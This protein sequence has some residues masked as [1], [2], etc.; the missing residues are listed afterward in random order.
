MKIKLDEKH[1]KW[2]LT[3]FLVILCSI[4]VFFAIYRFDVVSN[5]FHICGKILAPFIYGL[6]MAY[7]LCPMYNF[8]VRNTYALFGRGGKK[9]SK[10]LVI[11]KIM[12]TVVSMVFLLVVIAGVLWMIIPGVIDS[13]TKIVD[14]LPTGMENVQVWLDQRFENIPTAQNMV[15]GW[16]ENITSNTINFVTETLLPEYDNIALS[17]SE[18]VISM[19]GMLM[20]L[21]IGMVICVYF[22][23]SKDVFA[24]QV[25]KIVIGHFKE[26]TAQEILDGAKFTNKS[27]GGFINGKLID[28]LIIGCICFVVMTIFDWEY[29]LLISCIIGITNIIPF[30][31]PFIGAIPSAML[32]LI[33]D[34]MQ[35]LY[36]I[37]FVFIL[38]QFDGN[39]LGPKILGDS[40][41]LAS[42][43]VLF[44]VL[45]GGGLFGFAGMII[46]IPIFAVIYYYMSRGINNRLEKRGYS[47]DLSDY[48]VDS[49]RVKKEKKKKD[50]NKEKADGS[51]C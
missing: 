12:G 26:S 13:A 31:G 9:L 28:S 40:T 46:S 48:I 8:T 29:S 36:F 34:P 7:L 14:I 50:D 15:D 45:V 21:F 49:Y 27:F 25:K 20:N 43:W 42:F 2:G 41:G 32:L 47:T 5:S 23:N 24:A 30:F 1:L 51:N 16:L 39:I 11:S 6:I 3:A 4:L 17:I 33:V 22:L 37:I 10:A 44:A 38:Q 19:L 35:C 18:G